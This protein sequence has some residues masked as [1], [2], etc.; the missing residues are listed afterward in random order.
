M[1]YKHYK[2]SLHKI[3]YLMF[4][5]LKKLQIIS[6][7]NLTYFIILCLQSC[8][9]KDHLLKIIAIENRVYFYTIIYKYRTFLMGYNRLVFTF[10]IFFWFD[11]YYLIFFKHTILRKICKRTEPS[12]I[13][14]KKKIKHFQK[15]NS[16]VI[17]IN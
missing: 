10:D 11:V 13:I 7:H 6:A 3:P 8:N 16:V 9:F 1:L 15:R 12:D 4:L 2:I 5:K 14:L 17:I